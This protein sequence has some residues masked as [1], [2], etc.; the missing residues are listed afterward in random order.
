MRNIHSEDLDRKIQA[1]IKLNTMF[2]SVEKELK[3]FLSSFKGKLIKVDESLTAKAQKEIT[4]IIGTLQD[5][6]NVRTRVKVEYE[7]I[8][9]W[10]DLS[11][12]NGEYGCVYYSHD[13]ILGKV[14]TDNNVSMIEETFNY[15]KEFD[16]AEVKL[17]RI[18]VEKAILKIAELN[19]SLPYYYKLDLPYIS[20]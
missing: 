6:V 7:T 9:L 3:E 16:T 11:V 1:D 2:K 8:K 18:E 5:T 15:I 4:A 17:K 12:K 14:D 10:L 20:K 13:Y 19:D